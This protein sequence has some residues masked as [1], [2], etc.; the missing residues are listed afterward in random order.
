[1]LFLNWSWEK[2]RHICVLCEWQKAY[3][4]HCFL[5]SVIQGFYLFKAVFSKSNGD[6]RE[7]GF[8]MLVALAHLF[9]QCG[10]TQPYAQL[11]HDQLPV[12]RQYL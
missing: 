3:E 12:P 9:Y 8:L 1:M 2:P 7:V 6:H 11:L 4:I 5:N 10:T